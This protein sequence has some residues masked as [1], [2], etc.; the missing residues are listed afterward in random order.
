MTLRVGHWDTLDES[1]VFEYARGEI[2]S[3]VLKASVMCLHF[4]MQEE[5]VVL[6]H[7]N[8]KCHLCAL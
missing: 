7:T 6:E 5:E 4:C 3:S 2:F 8:D 1:L